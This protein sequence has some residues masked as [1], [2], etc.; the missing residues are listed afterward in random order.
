MLRAG[1]FPG[2][3]NDPSSLVAAARECEFAVHDRALAFYREFGDLT[4]RFARG[5]FNAVIHSRGDRFVPV[6]DHKL[7][8]ELRQVEG[9]LSPIGDDSF[10][11]FELLM[12]PIGAVFGY[13]DVSHRIYFI[14]SSGIQ[15]LETLITG[16]PLHRRLH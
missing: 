12:S 6:G 14:G 10:N 7:V 9:T 15:A 3:E 4:F 13:N 8:R 16:G 1:W 11:G 5:D 2:R